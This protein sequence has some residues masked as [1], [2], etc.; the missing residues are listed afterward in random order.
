MRRG[1]TSPPPPPQWWPPPP[2]SPPPG[3]QSVSRGR[4][5]GLGLSTEGEGWASNLSLH[6]LVCVRLRSVSRGTS[7]LRILSPSVPQ[8]RPR[9][10]LQQGPS[11]GTHHLLFQLVRQ[12]PVYSDTP[13]WSDRPNSSAS[14][15]PASLSVTSPSSPS[16]PSLSS[17]L[18]QE[19]LIEDQSRLQSGKIGKCIVTNLWLCRVKL[20]NFWC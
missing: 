5:P 7:P 18:S 17:Q 4:T 16:S 20:S 19:S 3:G 9:V 10:S 11:V 13:A 15:V 2:R 8:A 6:W 12:S 1:Q 14:S